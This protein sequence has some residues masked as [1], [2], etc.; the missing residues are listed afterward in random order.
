LFN[1]TS[2][3]PVE[4]DL[5]GDRVVQNDRTGRRAEPSYHAVEATGVAP[6]VADVRGSYLSATMRVP[7]LRDRNASDMTRRR[8]MKQWL[9]RVAAGTALGL[10]AIPVAMAGSAGAATA[11]QLACGSTQPGPCTETAHFNELNEMDTPAPPGAG[12]PAFLSNDFF[13][14]VGTGNGIEHITLNKAQDGWFTT[15][16]TGTITIT[17]YLHG[18]VDNDGNVTSVS[19]PDPN[20]LPYTGKITEWFGGSFNN[21]N[22]VVHNTF[23]FAGSTPNGESLRVFGLT[24]AAWTPGVDPTGPPNKGFD[25]FR[26]S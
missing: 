9:M 11:P 21:H 16:F 7:A 2:F 15:T 6:S 24:H 12:C 14:F 3:E 26:C 1:P 5:R 8:H 13:T 23:H 4:G 25:T 22:S 20:V 18:T 17:A 19:D 10:L